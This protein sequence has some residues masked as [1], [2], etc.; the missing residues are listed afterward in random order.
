MCR[1]FS[2][3]NRDLLCHLSWWIISLQPAGLVLSIQPDYIKLSAVM[4]VWGHSTMAKLIQN[5]G[6]AMLSC[7]PAGERGVGE[8]WIFLK[9][10]TVGIINVFQVQARA[11][12]LLGTPSPP[13]SVPPAQL[14]WIGH[15]VG[16]KLFIRRTPACHSPASW[17]L[18]LDQI[19]STQDGFALQQCLKI[20]LIIMTECG[21]VY[22]TVI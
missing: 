11:T 16:S 13:P 7:R 4:Q 20:L 1:P 8:W 15:L 21:S 9:G 12:E 14:L 3:T 18:P 22:A 6:E 5:K 2:W 10:Q 17:A 19:L